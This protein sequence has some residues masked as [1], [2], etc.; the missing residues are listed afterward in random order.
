[1]ND[2]EFKNRT[3][4]VTGGSRGIGRAICLRLAGTGARIAINY[5]NSEDA[6]KATL[7][8]VEAA[9]GSGA[10][11][12]AD[13]GNLE[14]M[15]AMYG[16]IE[17]ELGPVDMLVC[18]AGA[19]SAQDSL[20]M[21]FDLWY[22][23]MNTNMNGTFHTIWLAKDGMMERGF[24]RIVT[25]ASVA[26]L[27][28]NPLAKDRLLAYGSSKAGIIGLSRACAN[29]FS[30]KVR[31]NCIAPGFIETDM[32]ANA[33]EEGKKIISDAT[34]LGRLGK[35]EEIAEMAY[36]LL[37]DRS[38]YTTGQTILASGGMMTLP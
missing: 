20:T 36:F 3:V 14:Q 23:M 29:A 21:E 37:S 30:P 27:G 22:Q 4:L 16:K 11:Y 35:P 26:G 31:V 19:A 5:A 10:I 28:K 12:Q 7:A 24:G 9:G 13:I 8:D 38:S 34:M 18:N 15:K 32:T 6:A 2:E 33:S 25:M 1:M 17:A